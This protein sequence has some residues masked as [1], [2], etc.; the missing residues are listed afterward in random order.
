MGNFPETYSDANFL[1]DFRRHSIIKLAHLFQAS[2][3]VH[4]CHPLQQATGN[5]F[6]AYI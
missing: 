5:S 3:H 4:L 1:G 2:I 6:N